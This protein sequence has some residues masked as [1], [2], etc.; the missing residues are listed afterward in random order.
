VNELIF[1][2]L[3]LQNVRHYILLRITNFLYNL[4]FLPKGEASILAT[5]SVTEGKK[6][7]PVAGC[8]VQKGQLERQKKF[9]LI[10]NGHV[11]WKGKHYQ[12]LFLCHI[13]S[14]TPACVNI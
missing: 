9:K 14:P 4:F 2:I 6:K 7:I 13:Q 12:N 10:R 3:T 8:R 11:I 1:L 5:F